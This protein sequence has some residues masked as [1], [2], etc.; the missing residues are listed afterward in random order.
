MS[1]ELPGWEK[2]LELGLVVTHLRSFLAQVPE[3][4]R[5][6]V[7]RIVLEPYKEDFA[8]LCQVAVD[9]DSEKPILIAFV[10][11][12]ADPDEFGQFMERFGCDLTEVW[13][14]EGEGG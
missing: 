5:A 1:E 10:P 11:G 13:E 4:G 7:R 6:R 3:M 8:F 2:G 9:T 12:G 14:K